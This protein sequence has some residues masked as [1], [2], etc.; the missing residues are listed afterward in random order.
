MNT[1]T[2]IDLR[3]CKKG[4]KLISK[5]GRSFTYV[6]PLP[7]GDYYDHEITDDETGGRCTRTHDGHVFRNKR[8]PEDHDIVEI[9]YAETYLIRYWK[10]GNRK[11]MVSYKVDSVLGTDGT[12]QHEKSKVANADAYSWCC[13]WITQGQR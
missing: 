4:D 3:S 2:Y 1:T 7:Q 8:L 6:G 10:P 11:D 9:K 12:L 5:H 13:D